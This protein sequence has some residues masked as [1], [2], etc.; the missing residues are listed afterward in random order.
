MTASKPDGRRPDPPAQDEDLDHLVRRAMDEHSLMP[1]NEPDP[2]EADR[3]WYRQQRMKY[4]ITALVI[5]LLAGGASWYLVERHNKQ[6]ALDLEDAAFRASHEAQLA[7]LAERI[8]REVRELLGSNSFRSARSTLDKASGQGLPPE[9]WAGLDVEINNALSAR[10]GRL[11]EETEAELDDLAP[12]KAESLMAQLRLLEVPSDLASR[13]APLE[14]RLLDVKRQAELEP[15][16]RR[17]AD[18]RR[19]ALKKDYSKAIQLVREAKRLPRAGPEFDLWENELRD[20]V[21]GRVLVTGTPASAQVEVAGYRAVKIGEQLAGL[22]SGRVEFVVSADGYLSVH[23]H[24]DVQ[25]PALATMSI[26]LV[27]EAPGPV[28]ATHVLAGRCAQRVASSFYLLDKSNAEWAEAVKAVSSASAPCDPG[29][30]RNS[31]RDKDELLDDA[32]KDFKRGRDRH[33]V[34]ALD[35]LGKFTAIY[36]NATKAVLARCKSDLRR[37]FGDIERG[38]GDCWGVGDKPCDGCKARGK[39]REMGPCEACKAKGEKTHVS[40]RGTGKI[41]CKK[42]HGKGSIKKRR[43][44]GRIWVTRTE[45]CRPCSGKGRAICICENGKI[46]CSKCKGSRERKTVGECSE[47]SGRG[48]LSCDVCGG[49]GNRGSMKYERRRE[50]EQ[51]IARLSKP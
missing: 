18:S 41:K 12:D 16:K 14:R 36:P 37:M 29:R 6:K 51:A 49:S 7:E 45:S 35:E 38:C 46:T 23:G 22:A 4:G 15:A 11:I 43:K 44:E 19:A 27:P 40:C 9:V 3:L 21:G 39:R 42:C 17:V 28:W 30:A 48:T 8:P 31:T 32:V 33:A 50:L 26:E 47:C 10:C 20:M 1:D 24:A 25:Y 34:I 2:Y 13:I 5:L